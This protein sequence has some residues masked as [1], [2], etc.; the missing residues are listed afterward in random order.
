VH[1]H[2]D[3]VSFDIVVY[4]GH[5]TTVADWCG[6]ADALGARIIFPSDFDPVCY[7]GGLCI[8]VDL[9]PGNSILGRY[10]GELLGELEL[11]FS[12]MWLDAPGEMVQRSCE[13]LRGRMALLEER[14]APPIILDDLKKELATITGPRD[15]ASL[16]Q[17]R[18]RELLELMI[19]VPEFLRGGPEREL[20][21]LRSGV[22]MPHSPRITF[23][24]AA[25]SEPTAYLGALIAAVT[26]VEASDAVLV[27][28]HSGQEYRSAERSDAVRSVL[29]S[30]GLVAEDFVLA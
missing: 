26:L 6:S 28:T 1:A 4:G 20:L 2:G 27:N 17:A 29:D 18:E 30:S 16:K 10:S 5:T 25:G 15:L 21:A 13:Y 7:D 12:G 14:G 11:S 22:W 24:V 3:S 19:G 23:S 8:S 9:K